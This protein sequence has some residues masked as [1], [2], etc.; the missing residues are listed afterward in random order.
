MPAYVYMVANRKHGTLYTGVTTDL[1]ARITAHKERRGSAFAAKWVCDR[2][3]WYTTFHD[4]RDAIAREKR[5]KRWRRAHKRDE[6]E[7]ANPH[8][9]DLWFDL[10][11]E[12]T[13]RALR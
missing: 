8:W 1:A 3:V 6:I 11:G 2:L 13:T 10:V 12:P 7:R 5:V 4:V 9:S